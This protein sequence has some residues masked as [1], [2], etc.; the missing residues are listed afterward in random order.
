MALSY[1]I[2]NWN[3]SEEEWR[4]F[5]ACRNVDPRIF[6]PKSDL[7][8]NQGKLICSTCPVRE[9]CLAWALATGQRDGIW[10]GK[11]SKERRRLVKAGRP[12]AEAA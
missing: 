11:T 12:T 3:S 1:M 2:A 6:F 10:G 9:Q 8:S 5:A 4:S 7:F